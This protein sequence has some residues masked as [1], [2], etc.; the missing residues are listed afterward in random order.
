[1]NKLDVTDVNTTLQNTHLF[2]AKRTFI[3]HVLA[4]K[5]HFNNF[6]GLKFY[7][8]LCSVIVVELSRKP[9]VTHQFDIQLQ[10]KSL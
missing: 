7:R 5:A 4:G 6:E 9:N 2:G 1:M 8:V 3:D 10:P